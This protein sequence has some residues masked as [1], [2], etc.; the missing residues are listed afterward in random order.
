MEANFGGCSNVTKNRSILITGGAGYIGSHVVL[1]VREAG[2]SLVVIDDLSSALD[3]NTERLLWDRLLSRG[4]SARPTCLVVSH[5]Q[6]VLRSADQIV[7]LRDGRID[8]TGTLE[9]LLSTCAEMRHIWAAA[10]AA[11]RALAG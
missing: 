11:Q 1:A 9:H 8:G 3:T 2:H 10:G 6:R 7:A 4:A 5:R